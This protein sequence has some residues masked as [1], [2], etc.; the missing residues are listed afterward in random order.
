MTY[1]FKNDDSEIGSID[2]I[3]YKFVDKNIIIIKL[4]VL[5]SNSSI[6]VLYK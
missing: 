3:L 5:L 1:K 2:R 4:I 6:E